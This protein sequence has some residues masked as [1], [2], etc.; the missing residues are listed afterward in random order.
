MKSLP[1]TFL[2]IVLDMTVAVQAETAL[3]RIGA[4]G[5]LA[6]AARAKQ[7]AFV[8]FRAACT[9]RDPAEPGSE[10]EQQ[11]LHDLLVAGD[12]SALVLEAVRHTLGNF[13]AKLRAAVGALAD[14]GTYVPTPQ[15][16]RQIRQVLALRLDTSA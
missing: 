5:K 1:Q 4:L 9:A 13:V 11:A 7:E 10:A 16:S 6:D 12:E 3:A 8:T 2:Q 15:P 14:P